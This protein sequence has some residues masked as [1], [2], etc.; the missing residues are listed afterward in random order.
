LKTD[1]MN[2]D[3]SKIFDSVNHSLLLL[4][5]YQIGLPNN[6]LTWILIYFNGR[7]QKV[8]F[9]NADSKMIYVTSGV[10][11]GSHLGPLLFTLFI[12]DLPSIVAY[13][14]VLMYDDDLKLWVCSQILIDSRN[15]VSTPFWIKTIWNGLAM[16]FSQTALGGI[17][18]LAR[19]IHFS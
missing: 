10:P 17:E 14:R 9:K 2:T 16:L 15:G 18:R 12:N 19:S 11:Q 8:I 3:F 6:L 5:L 1:V 13:S 4:K 7:F